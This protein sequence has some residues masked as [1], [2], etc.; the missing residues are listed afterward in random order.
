MLDLITGY[1]TRSDAFIGWFMVDAQRHRKGIGSQLIADVRA[2]M[3]AQ[4][5]TSLTLQC[6]AENTDAVAFWESQGFVVQKTEKDTLT[7]SRTI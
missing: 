3:K 2:A 6:P 1:P 7:M 5:F 4:G